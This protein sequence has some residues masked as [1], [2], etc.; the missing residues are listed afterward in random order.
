MTDDSKK[1]LI[2]AV[3]V[4]IAGVVVFVGFQNSDE[5]RRT[6]TPAVIHSKENNSPHSTLDNTT[7]YIQ[8]YGAYFEI[9]E[10][11][12]TQRPAPDRH[13]KNLFLSWTDLNE[14]NQIDREPFG[15]DTEDA[16]VINAVLPFEDCV[17]HVGDRGWGNGLWNDLQSRIY[18]TQLTPDEIVRRLESDG[19]KT[20]QSNFEKAS[21]EASTYNEWN[22]FSFRILDA[23]THFMLF[24]RLTFFLRRE[25]DATVVFVI[26]QADSFEDEVAILLNSFRWEK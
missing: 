21:F 5:V 3:I 9:P 26:L 6:L 17:A 11:W 25:N 13:V 22:K 8:P 10:A 18:I 2:I 19:L 4:A 24:K 20:A 12:L 14:V 16:D 7:V 1:R 23:P 15:F